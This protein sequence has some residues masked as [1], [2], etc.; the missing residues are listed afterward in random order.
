MTETSQYTVYQISLTAFNGFLHI[1]PTQN[2]KGHFTQAQF[3]LP[4]IL[5]LVEASH[6]N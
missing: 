1:S 4:T 6:Q 2:Y 3:Y 5:I